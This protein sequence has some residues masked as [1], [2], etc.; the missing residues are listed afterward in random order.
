MSRTDFSVV[1]P[2]YNKRPHIRRAVDSVFRQSCQEF[3]LILIDDA[4]TDGS[5]DE[6]KSIED[7]RVVRARRET[8]GPG[9]YAARN[10]GVKMARGDWIAFLDADDEWNER[11]LEEFLEMRESFPDARILCTGFVYK[12]GSREVVNDFTS[13]R[14]DRGEKEPGRVGL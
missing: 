5:M 2:I 12:K 13:R 7:P 6:L 4:S 9:G 14:T 10:L 1:I 3:E 11:I 8:P